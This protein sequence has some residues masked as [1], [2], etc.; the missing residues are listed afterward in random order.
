MPNPNRE[1]DHEVSEATPVANLASAIAPRVV[2]QGWD[3]AFREMAECKD[4]RLIDDQHSPNVF[5][6][7]EWKW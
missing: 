2:R 6:Q 1:D 7:S 5:D 3:A 4:D